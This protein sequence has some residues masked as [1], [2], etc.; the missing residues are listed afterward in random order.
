MLY[1]S[2]SSSFHR[3]GLSKSVTENEMRAGGGGEEGGSCGCVFFLSR[4]M[5]AAKMPEGSDAAIFILTPL[6]SRLTQKLNILS[7]RPHEQAQKPM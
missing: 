2:S 5:Q 3:V 7:I 4:C 1:S 6:I